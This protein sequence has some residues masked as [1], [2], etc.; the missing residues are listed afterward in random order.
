M[1]LNITTT[2]DAD[3]NV[4][5]RNFLNETHEKISRAELIRRALRD[6]IT[7]HTKIR[8]EGASNEHERTE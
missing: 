3:L 1:Y 8:T 4:S 5:I 6:Y 7:T 2:I